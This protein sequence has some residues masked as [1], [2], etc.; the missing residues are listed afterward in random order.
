M[1]PFSY[2]VRNLLRDPIRLLQKIGGAGAVVFLIFAAGAFNQGMEQVLSATGSGKNVMFL[3]AGSE[4]SVERSEITVQSETLVT[5]GVRGIEVRAGQP[6]VS[7]EVHYMG[8]LHFPDVQSVQALLRG[9]TPSAFEVHREVRVVEGRFP[10]S[11]E[12]MIGQLAYRALEVSPSNLVPGKTLVFEGQEMRI[13][14]IFAAPGTIM[15]SEIWFNRSDLMMLTQR[16]NLSCVVV[17][18]ENAENY[19]YAEL[20]AQQRLDL[21]LVAL[22]EVD[23]YG[24]LAEFY[25]PIRGMIWLTALLVGLGAV[26]G[27]MNMLYAAFAAR[28]REIA[29][30]Q[31]IGFSRKAVFVSLILESLLATLAG[32]LIAGFLAILLLEGI[33]V[34]FSLGTFHL[35]LALE[36]IGFGVATGIG[37][38]TLGATPPIVRC[39]RAPLPVA[40]RSN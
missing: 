37:L 6:A 21:E 17:R 33:T 32:T 19:G 26:F 24:K 30:L 11:G 22:R 38:G 1:L 25:A 2:A 27:G 10:L 20:F 35:A 16:E 13:S 34:D 8:K 12:V 5:A 36:T 15:E 7:G 31:A 40:L 39:L 28:K 23:Y 9:V 29:T 14:G 3:S 18:L 4:E